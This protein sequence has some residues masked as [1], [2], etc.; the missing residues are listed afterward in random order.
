MGWF[1]GGWF[2]GVGLPFG[3]GADVLCF[4]FFVFEVAAFFSPP[5]RWSGLGAAA[6]CKEPRV[7]SGHGPHDPRR[8]KPQRLANARWLGWAGGQSEVGVRVRGYVCRMDGA[9]MGRDRFAS[10][11]RGVL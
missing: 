1:V 7:V 2:A 5:G 9:G 3:D 8:T 10:M 11:Y 4:L 6:V